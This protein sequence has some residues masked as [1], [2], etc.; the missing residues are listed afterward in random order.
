MAL[1]Q[2]GLTGLATPLFAEIRAQNGSM[3][4]VSEHF[5]YSLETLDA[6]HI[7]PKVA[8]EVR[9]AICRLKGLLLPEFSAFHASGEFKWI[10]LKEPYLMFLLPLLL[11]MLP[12]ARFLHLTRD[13]RTVHR[14]HDQ[15]TTTFQRK[16]YGLDGLA[17]LDESISQTCTALPHAGRDRL[18]AIAVWADTQRGLMAWAVR[19][20][21]PPAYRH[22]RVEDVYL[23]RDGKQIQALF[24]WL[25]VDLPLPFVERLLAGVCR[26]RHNYWVSKRD[27][28]DQG[29][30]RW[31]DQVAG[32]VLDHMGYSRPE[33]GGA[34]K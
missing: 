17:K 28:R 31:V 18:R 13:V 30:S 3:A 8:A 5:F 16:L 14:F 4:P 27:R 10:A 2:S 6:R 1:R 19:E 12:H 22:L 26:K 33:L 20:L 24:A 32:D 25:D 29:L 9:T 11:H 34:R 23:K 21:G 7:S 15:G